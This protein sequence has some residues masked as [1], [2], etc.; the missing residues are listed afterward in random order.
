M[1]TGLA[2]GSCRVRRSSRPRSIRRGRWGGSCTHRIVTASAGHD[3]ALD[4]GRRSGGPRRRGRLTPSRKGSA[5]G[6]R[7]SSCA[8]SVTA[9]MS[10]TTT[11]PAICRESQRGSR[12]AT[13]GRVRTADC[14]GVDLTT[15]GFARGQG[16]VDHERNPG[17]EPVPVH[18]HDLAPGGHPAQVKQGFP[19]IDEVDAVTDCGSCSFELG[20]GENSRATRRPP[21]IAISGRPVRC[22]Q[23]QSLAVHAGSGR[24][25]QPRRGRPQAAINAPSQSTPRRTAYPLVTARR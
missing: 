25:S 13:A 6:T 4:R 7:S 8:Y 22:R 21:T 20:R 14:G 12:S 10:A 11:T 3:Q 5:A 18:V 1:E 24:T 23:P 17:L 15:R 16:E 9:P 2:F 19:V